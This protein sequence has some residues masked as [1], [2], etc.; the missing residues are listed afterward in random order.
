MLKH[1]LHTCIRCRRKFQIE[2][3]SL[4]II[5]WV[6]EKWFSKALLTSAFILWL[7][8]SSD[9]L[10][11]GLQLSKRYLLRMY[12]DLV[13]DVMMY[14]GMG[15]QMRSFRG[16]A[17]GGKWRICG[18]DFLGRSICLGRLENGRKLC[19]CDSFSHFKSKM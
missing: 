19:S 8:N 4:F 2:L 1:L 17:C 12:V 5:F 14:V 6:T 15:V 16:S 13:G 9:L 11:Y 3:F 7:L 10:S 18:K